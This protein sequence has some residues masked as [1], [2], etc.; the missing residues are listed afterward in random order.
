MVGVIIF[1]RNNYFLI[2][3]IKKGIV[4]MDNI[5]SKGGREPQ[6]RQN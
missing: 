6:I 2:L 3:L 5:T 1:N 4:S